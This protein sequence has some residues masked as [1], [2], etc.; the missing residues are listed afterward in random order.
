MRTPRVQ[1]LSLS[2]I[3]TPASG[4][5]RHR[6]ARGR[7]AAA[8]ASAR[9]ATTVL[10]AFS[11]GRWPRCAPAPRG[12]PRPRTRAR[13]D[14]TPH[15][16]SSSCIPHRAIVRRSSDDPR[17][18]EE[19]GPEARVRRCASAPRRD[20]ATA[21]PHRVGRRYAGD[22]RAVGARRSCRSA[23]RSSA[24]ARMSPSWRANSSISAR[25]ARDARARR[26]RDLRFVDGSAGMPDASMALEGLS[27]SGMPGA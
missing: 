14:R 7:S 27:G 21:A 2:A 10:N 25:R 24:Y 16:A 26:W 9:S 13:P 8:R 20:R 1:R 11:W 12:R 23:G 19:A 5:S 15:L 18:L 22:D 3:G 17:H 4:A 6:A